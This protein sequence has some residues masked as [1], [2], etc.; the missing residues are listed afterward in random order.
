MTHRGR[1][2]YLTCNRILRYNHSYRLSLRF[3]L[4]TI[5]IQ[6]T[7]GCILYKNPPI[8]EHGQETRNQTHVPWVPGKIGHLN[9]RRILERPLS[10]LNII[11]T[12]LSSFSVGRT[13]RRIVIMLLGYVFPNFEADSTIGRLKLYDFLGDS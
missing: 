3:Q 13:R 2:T 7:V 1:I 11:E 4:L 9:H 5:K 12:R 6:P 10:L 8:F